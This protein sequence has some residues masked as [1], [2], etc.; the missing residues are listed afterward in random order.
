MG[1]FDKETQLKVRMVNDRSAYKADLEYKA[2]LLF[3]LKKMQW[4]NLEHFYGFPIQTNGRLVL[5]AKNL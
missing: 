3:G 4:A 2:K 5:T 1:I